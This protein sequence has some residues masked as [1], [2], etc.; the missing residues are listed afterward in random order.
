[1]IGA[2]KEALTTRFRD[3]LQILE[4][5]EA[6]DAEM[7]FTDTLSTSTDK[8]R[9][10]GR[11]ESSSDSQ[12]EDPTRQQ[13]ARFGGSTTRNDSHKRHQATSRMAQ[14]LITRQEALA[15]FQIRKQEISL[16]DR[17]KRWFQKEKAFD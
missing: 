11:S 13:A 12:L 3:L 1:M 14:K 5:K 10:T 8:E 2:V 4:E 6:E 9:S 17:Q 7:E 15:I 16:K